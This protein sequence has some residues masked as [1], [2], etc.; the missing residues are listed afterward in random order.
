MA[1]PCLSDV[2]V[3]PAECAEADGA[4]H[5]VTF[6]FGSLLEEEDGEEVGVGGGSAKGGALWGGGSRS[7][8]GGG[9]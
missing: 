8:G 6:S 7:L 2:G 4:V 9:L 3:D 5:A 1:A